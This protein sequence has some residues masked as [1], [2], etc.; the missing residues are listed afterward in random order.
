MTIRRRRRDEEFERNYYRSRVSIVLIGSLTI[1]LISM[2]LASVLFVYKRNEANLQASLS[3]K[4]NSIQALVENNCREAEDFNDLNNL[5]FNTTLQAIGNITGVDI[6]LY[7][8]DGRVFLSTNTDLYEQ[9]IAGPRIN[10]EAFYNIAYK[11]KRYFICEEEIGSHKFYSLYAP[12]FNEKG[13]MI[14]ILGT[15]Y[16]DENHD[17]E[18]EAVRHSVTILTVFILLLILT[19][20]MASAIVNR[21]FKPLVIMGK[22]MKASNIEDLDYIE[23][24]RDD[25]IATLVKSYNRMVTDLSESTKKLAQAERD[26]AWS[27]MAR[28][29]AHEIKNPLTPMKLQLQRII[30]LKDKNDP[31]WQEKFDEVTKVVLEHID[32]LTDTANEFS[33]FAK[34][35]SEEHTVIDLDAILKDE[36]SMFDSKGGIDFSYIGLE[37]AV[38]MGPKPQLTRVFVNL[39]GNA[40]QAVEGL[41]DAKVVVSLRKSTK[42][43]YYDIVF[44]DNGPGVSKENVSKLFTPNFTTKSGGTGL[45]L[46]ISRSI[47]EK[48]NATINYS[49][50]FTLG[51]ACFKITYPIISD[52]YKSEQDNL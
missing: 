16:T 25:E 33:T 22:K 8:P 28:Q 44:E 20:M 37:K 43:G 41:E 49:K 19:R 13:E 9:M 1:T 21:M 46:A 51:G 42:N 36:I 5:D 10:D 45:G 12:V 52:G 39:L 3:D 14:A 11:N 24:D 2:A 7:T 26:K 29:V 35:Y 32:I 40:V 47:L 23:Y 34:L 31:Q 18:M 48:C 27:S 30:R 17:F 6:T 4:I 15:P 38:T 50:S